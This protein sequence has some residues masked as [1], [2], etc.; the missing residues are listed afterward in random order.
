MEVRDGLS[1]D[2]VL[3]V[4]Q[5]SA[6][7][8][9]ADVSL[10]T[11]LTSDL[12]L[13]TP[14]LSAAMDTVTEADSAIAL[15]SVGGLGIIHRFLSISEQAKEVERVV[16]AGERA[17]G[18]VGIDEDFIERAGALVDVGAACVVVDVA[19]GHM[20]RCLD[21]VSEIRDEFPDVDLLAGNVATPAG[22]RDLAAAGADCVKVGVGPG[23]HCTT[24]EVAGAGVPQL[25][26]VDECADAAAECGVTTVAD[27]GIT[28]SADAVKALLA[29]ADAVMV[30]GLLAGTT[31]APGEVV[32]CDGGQ[33]KRSRGMASA[34]AGDERT[35]K[36]GEV[37]AAE[38]VAGLVP[39]RG[40]V[41]DVVG[42][43]EAGIR[44]GMSYCGGADLAAARE[45]A[46]FVRNSAGAQER[47]GAHGGV[48]ER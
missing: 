44:S 2:D 28:D 6:I 41:A 15:S 11:R 24:R 46:A 29:G 37:A 32:E 5:R 25:T 13:E 10:E 45:N 31:E 3:I 9:R 47:A 4:P 34:E 39:Y 22:V 12:V 40:D 18:A 48:R 17:G 21:A 27:G 42:E 30:G 16:A 36:S 26:A 7:A 43:L 35:D 38:G 33:Y 8:H 19:H 23:S 20:E 1:Y 14:V